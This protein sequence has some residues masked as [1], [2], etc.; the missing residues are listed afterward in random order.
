MTNIVD[1][2]DHHNVDWEERIAGRNILN[3]LCERSWIGQGRRG[4]GIVCTNG[5][6]ESDDGDAEEQEMDEAPASPSTPMDALANDEKDVDAADAAQETNEG[7]STPT[8]METNETTP[9]PQ[10]ESQDLR[11]PV[12]NINI[13][14]PSNHCPRKSSSIHS[15]LISHIEYSTAYRFKA[16]YLKHLGGDANHHH[17]PANNETNN[18]MTREQLETHELLRQHL[19]QGQ[20]P[21][22]ALNFPRG[23]LNPLQRQRLGSNPNIN[24]LLHALPNRP[25]STPSVS[26][27]SLSFSPDG[28]TLASTHGDH[29]V[30]ITCVHSG[31]LLR[32]LE[33][34][35]RTPWTVKYHPSNSRIVASGCLGYQ[36]RIWDW[37]Y[38]VESWRGEWRRLNERRL[39]GRYYVN[40]DCATEWEGRCS[41]RGVMDS[42][43]NKRKTPS[44]NED[45]DGT[46]TFLEMNIPSQDPLWYDLQSETYNYSAGMGI[47]LN[48]IRLNHAIIS[49]A[50]H[51]G[52]EILA[53]A[54]GSM[55][56]LW[57]YD[58]EGRKARKSALQQDVEMEDSA[59]INNS[60]AS[61]QQQSQ[62]PTVSERNLMNRNRTSDF[63]ASRTLVISHESALRCVH[64]PPDGKSLIIGGVNP[65]SANEGLSHRH[66]RGRGG[67]SGGGMSF[68]LKLWDFDLEAVLNSELTTVPME[69]GESNNGE[70]NDGIRLGGAVSDEGEVTWNFPG[71]KRPLSN[72]SSLMCC[73]DG[74]V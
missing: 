43:R 46:S 64:F 26:T 11:T 28:R 22:P 12:Q 1:H 14:T 29:T 52:G 6:N 58:E 53:V 7:P 40:G 60:N 73:C 9:T 2:D 35:P 5:L 61:Q 42:F 27:I 33:G 24:N 71:V 4:R 57:D 17:R 31:K 44:S 65:S 37:D 23:L 49:L 10:N 56:H 38:R 62:R 20:R 13:H 70:N 59:T 45:D 32:T 72:V 48:M 16:S 69:G 55:L 21:L 66:S 34:H 19:R 63:P 25:T 50:F 30:K 68:H 8:A 47:C 18:N 41:P 3:I 39:G 51:P 54:S 74:F 67:M 36:V 15:E